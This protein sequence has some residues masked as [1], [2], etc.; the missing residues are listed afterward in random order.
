M[1]A[2][3]SG[4]TRLTNSP[5]NEHHP[6]WSPD[7]MRIVFSRVMDNNTSD[8]YVINVDGS[9]IARLTN[10]P[11]TSEDYPDWSPD[12]KAIL[13]SA[14]GGGQSGIY[15]MDAD[16]SNVRLLMAGPLH[17]PRWS[18]D[19]KYIAFDG[20]P[21]GCKFEIYV[22]KTDGAG[23]RQVTEHPAG[24][25]S[26]NKCPSW[27]P[28][29]KQLVYFSSDR[30]PDPGSDILV[31]NVEGSGETALTHGKTDLHRG[32]FYPDWSPVP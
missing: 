8:L 29:G 28:D 16:G 24:C 3:G 15:I 2:D 7:G 32:G 21:A 30:S 31:I 11:D 27:S 17:Y 14:F 18:P 23:M 20:E 9:G 19:G 4:Q 5:E 10:T 6:R 1:N 13:F 22:M 25:G 26:Y 12:G